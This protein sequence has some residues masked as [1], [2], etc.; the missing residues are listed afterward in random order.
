MGKTTA[1]PF[2]EMVDQGVYTCTVEKDEAGRKPLW[3]SSPS[4]PSAPPLFSADMWSVNFD[5]GTNKEKL[6][7][8]LDMRVKQGLVKQDKQSFKWTPEGTRHYEENYES[9]DDDE[10]EPPKKSSSPSSKK[11]AAAGSKKK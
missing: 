9:D 5:T 10:P 6:K 8:A 7:D 3:G 2:D 4:A 11:V 1:P